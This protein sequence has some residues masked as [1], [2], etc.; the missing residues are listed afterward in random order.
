MQ[1]PELG[2]SVEPSSV[3]RQSLD[4]NGMI[5]SARQVGWLRTVIEWD[6]SSEA[7]LWALDCQGE[8]QYSHS[9]II[10]LSTYRLGSGFAGII[11]SLVGCDRVFAR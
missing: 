3:V 1:T 4:K 9:W 5:S 6:R 7:H 10:L 2:V 11:G 8:S